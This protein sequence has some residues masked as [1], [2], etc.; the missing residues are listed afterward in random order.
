MNRQYFEKVFSNERMQKFFDRHPGDEAKAIVHY[1]LNIELSES[2]YPI[3]SVFEI[4]LRNSLN[5]ELT[6]HFGTPD[7]YIHIATTPGLKEL[8]QEISNAIRHIVKRGETITA[9]KVVAELT[10][11]F[12]V[13]LLNVEYELILW[14]S[15][16]RSFPYMPK[17]DR[18]RHHVSAPIN[19]I[20]NLR[21]RVF[22]HEPIS[23]NLARLE[24]IHADII[25]VIGW[26][27]KDLPT[28]VS[29]IDSFQEVLKDA[30]EK[31]L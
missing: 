19:K 5:R 6:T 3:L 26:L 20:R 14:K 18:T 7:W 30:K 31:L 12:W 22:H 17:S 2:L 28:F 8:N 10:L 23:W 4:A 21:N 11:G 9:T 15:L 27:N 13:R 29:P 1:Q 24:F 25:K 16:R